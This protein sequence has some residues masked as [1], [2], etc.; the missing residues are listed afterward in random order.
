MSYAEQVSKAKKIL[1][2][3]VPGH[4]FGCDCR[5]CAAHNAQIASVARLLGEV[6]AAGYEEGLAGR[7]K[8]RLEALVAR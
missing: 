8:A 5:T 6:H 4:M 3:R 2:A 1:G 7:R